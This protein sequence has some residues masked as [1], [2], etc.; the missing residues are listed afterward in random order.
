MKTIPP[1]CPEPESGVRYWR[2]LDELA[3]TPDFKA[4]LD[5]EFPE[6]ASELTDPTSRR[7]FVKLMGASFAL[8][9]LGVTGCRRPEEK[10]LPFGKQPE[11]YFH[12]V[13]QYFATS[14]PTRTGAI[15]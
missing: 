15:P 7:G 14:M 4:F 9:G 10:I 11:G 2:G 6:G 1:P 12:G 5:R 8:A 13:P 3:G